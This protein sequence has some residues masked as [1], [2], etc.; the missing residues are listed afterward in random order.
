M[1]GLLCNFEFKFA[2][3]VQDL[4]GGDGLTLSTPL[5]ASTPEPVTQPTWK[6]SKK[7]NSVL[8]E[9]FVHPAKTWNVDINPDMEPLDYFKITFPEDV[10][11]LIVDE[12][13]RFAAQTHQAREILTKRQLKWNDVT[14]DEIKRYIAIRILMGIDRKPHF[15]HYWTKDQY[16]TSSVV[17]KIMSSNRF[18]EIQQNLHFANNEEQVEGDRLAKIRTFWDKLNEKSKSLINVGQNL[19]IDESL[20]KFKGR[21]VWKQYIP[22]KRNRFGIKTFS[23]VDSATGFVV[24]SLI[25]CGKG[26]EDLRHSMNIYGYGGAVVLDLLETYFRKYHRVFCD[27]YFTSPTLARKLLDENTYLTGTLRSNRKNCPKASKL[28]KGDMEVFTA[29]GTN[30]GIMIEY[31]RDKKIVRML[32]SG[33]THNSEAVQ[34]RTGV[35]KEKPE[36]VLEYNKYA[37]GVDL[38]DM[39]IHFHETGRKCLKWYGFLL[40]FNVFHFD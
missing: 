25:Y 23:L 33:V 4:E 6:W 29:D 2:E 31:W 11:Q 3:S 10:V 32:S 34:L 13:N 19:A 20:I 35:M 15:E 17:P 26:S 14:S 38:S 9:D 37:R 5:T 7:S 18:F 28:K 21:L 1:N 12:V 24:I 27:N 8:A 36:T 16:L 39:Q 30:N 40:N 22:N